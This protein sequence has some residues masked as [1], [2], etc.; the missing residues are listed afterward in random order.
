MPTSNME[1]GE[2]QRTIED[3]KDQ[4]KEM[5]IKM[6]EKIVCYDDIIS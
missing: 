5:R 3:T 1:E 6:N 4:L 2:L